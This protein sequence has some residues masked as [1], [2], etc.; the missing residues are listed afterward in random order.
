MTDCIGVVLHFRASELTEACIR[1]L[2]QEGLGDAIVV[3]NSEDGGASL[4]DLRARLVDSSMRL[5]FVEPGR[6]LGY[7][8]GINAALASLGAS[9]GSAH[10]LLIN[11][12]AT[13]APGT[14]RRLADSVADDEAVVAAPLI[15]GPTGLVP[16]RTYYRHFSAM[17]NPVGPGMHGHALLGGACL[18]ISRRL[19]RLPLFDE[20]FFFY[21]DDIEF[22]HRV[23]RQ[24]GVLRDV[25]EGVVRHQGSAASGNGS[26]FYE[27]HMTRAHL[28]LVQRLDQGRA[29]RWAM[30]A[31]RA[32]LLPLRACVRMMRFRS[33]TAW[34]A[35]LM[36]TA[37]VA[38][39]RVRSLTPPSGPRA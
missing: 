37:D 16:A 23:V 34:R 17:I 26:L 22:G 35:L 6:N 14:L 28:L 19:L 31:G 32:V 21:G 11:S 33:L 7:A 8:A 9:L 5:T 27:Y 39:G 2:A 18:L 12:D 4:A 1:S 25:P 13:L 29:C 10:V 3:D 24:G 15:D 38:S 36:A 30:Y 20:T